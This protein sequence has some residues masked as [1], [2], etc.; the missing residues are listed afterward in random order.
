[1][2]TL[3]DWLPVEAYTGNKRL[4][5]FFD[6]E[7][8]FETMDGNWIGE[9]KNVYAWCKLANGYAVGWNE[10]PGRGWSFPIVKVK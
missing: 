1:M 3:K 2:K 6:V 8:T 9:Q 10:N 7:V 5:K 4:E